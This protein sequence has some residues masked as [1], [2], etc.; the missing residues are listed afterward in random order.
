M[1]DNPECVSII[2]PTYNRCHLL[3]KCINS[4][5]AQTFQKW[6]LIVAD[7]GS[8]DDTQAVIAEISKRDSRIKYHRNAN[9]QGLP[10]NRNIA[11]S[12][13]KYDLIMF[14]EDDLIL[15]PKCIEILIHTYKLL[16]KEKKKIGAIA[17]R[18]ITN[19]LEK[20]IISLLD[21]VGY[22]G[23]TKPSV[24][25]I[26][27]YTGVVKIN[28]NLQ[29]NEL[30]EAENV[31]ACSLYSKS[32]L[33]GVGGYEENAYKGTFFYEDVDL[34]CRIRKRGCL[35]FYQSKAFAYHNMSKSGGCRASNRIMQNYFYLR[36][37]IIFLIRIFRYKSIY[38][39]PLFSWRILREITKDFR[40]LFPISH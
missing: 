34:N 37:H 38:M 4:V 12:L 27:K 36:N 3:E 25:Q 1:S 14:I 17:P 15:D 23:N 24:C 29:I 33:L 8:L 11:I 2:L 19:Y 9:N 30:I 22:D 20:P 6:E 39:I 31:H 28:Y 7:D 21:M 35:L 26:D 40:L 32:V 5:F 16:N 10:R 13:A 18:L